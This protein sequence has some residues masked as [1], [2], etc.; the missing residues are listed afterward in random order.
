MAIVDNAS[1]A[2]GRFSSLPMSQQLGLLVGLAASIA[3]GIWVVLWSKE[4][5]YRPLFS[6][7]SASDSAEVADVLQT[8]G[9]KYKMNKNTGAIM[10]SSSDIHNA[11]MK[12]AADGLPKGS[13]N[14]Y[15]MFSKST[16]FNTSQFMENARYRH[17]LE[18][19]L[20]R[21]IT[22]FNS[23]KTARVHLA[24]PRQS[25]FVSSKRKPK[26]SV[27]VEVYTGQVLKKNTIAS[28][29][30]L[31]GSSVANLA[32]ND[33]TVVD[34]NGQLL[35]EGSGG[36][37]ISMTDKFFDYRKQMENSYALKIQDILEPI[38]GVGRI[39][40]KVS[41]DIDFTSSEQTREVYNPDLPALRSEQ[42]MSEQKAIGSGAGGVVGATANQPTQDGTLQTQSAST[43]QNMEAG[44]RDQ[45][46]QSTKNYELDKTISHTQQRPGRIQRL[47]VA[48][49]LDDKHNY[50]EKTG[51]VIT[52]PLSD[53]ELSK[54]KQLVADSI[55]LELKRGDSLNVIN[56]AFNTPEP[57]EA[58]PELPIY[59]QDWFWSIMKQSI[60]AAFILFL[61]FGILKPALKSLAMADK[62]L[63]AATQQA[64][65]DKKED[66][67]AL[68]TPEARIDAAKNFA[69]SNPKGVAEVLKTW[70]DGG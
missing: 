41:A 63:L 11:R 3:I 15:E 45:R 29:T 30:N 48:V 50:D 9:F 70:V 52:K 12:L 64:A 42:L 36:G 60:G 16:S 61:V 54:I 10:I 6:N 13:G 23:I 38:L 37:V 32:S 8:N 5:I 49:L 14:G 35:S 40:A 57:I 58:L 53:E 17:A 33:V 55:G 68:D 27:F 1:H 24:I 18:T 51:K 65:K 66:V 28:I 44:G 56:V 2:A 4:P 47:T 19:E 67:V 26:A 20:S 31:V 39:K 62:R 34:Q 69:S 7:L 21:T 43:N 22:N 25:A 46:R 59:E